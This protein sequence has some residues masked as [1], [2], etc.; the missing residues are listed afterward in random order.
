MD[1]RKFFSFLPLGA[2]VAGAAILSESNK[3]EKPSGDRGLLSL[4]SYDDTPKE[5]F[6]IGS[7]HSFMITPINQNPSNAVDLSVGKDGKLWLRSSGEDWKRVV[8]EG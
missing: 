2:V 1:R 5:R 6:R 3:D 8:T 7:D 4:H